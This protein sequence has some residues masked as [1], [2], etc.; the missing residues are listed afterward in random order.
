VAFVT[1][2][3]AAR[4]TCATHNIAASMAMKRVNIGMVVKLLKRTLISAAFVVATGLLSSASLSQPEISVGIELVLALD[5]SASMNREEFDLQIKG[6][7]AAF[8]DPAVLKAI[9][10]LQPLGVVV[11]VTQWGGPGEN[12]V[13]VP[14]TA[15]TNA[16]EGQAFGF[17]VSL[18]TQRFYATTTSITTAIED[19]VALLESNGFDGQRRVI[20]I[21]GDGEDNSGLDLNAARAMARAAGVTVNGL[22]IEAEQ[23]QLFSY[24][25][26]HVITGAD[27]FAVKAKDFQDY[28]RAIREKLLRELRPL[29]S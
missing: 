12:R 10:D 20:D 29:E 3:S 25:R 4:A 11:A 23:S 1:V 24:Y 6:I 15:I 7:A 8:R 28:A 17:L 2:I 16:M 26:E 13:V 5:S 27:S 19:N 14:F 9:E 21:S 22:A 18:G